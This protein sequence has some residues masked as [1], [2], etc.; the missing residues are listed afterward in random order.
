MLMIFLDFT[1][2]WLLLF[3]HLVIIVVN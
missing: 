3:P 1:P 2:L